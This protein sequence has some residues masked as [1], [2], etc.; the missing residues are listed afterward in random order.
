LGSN[1]FPNTAY[2]KPIFPVKTGI[3]EQQRKPGGVAGIRGKL[4]KN[5]GQM[6]EGERCERVR[7]VRARRLHR[8]PSGI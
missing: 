4:A 7:D 6:I 1:P 2:K 8:F 3:Y 5:K